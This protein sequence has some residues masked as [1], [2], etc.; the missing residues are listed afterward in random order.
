MNMTTKIMSGQ[1]VGRNPNG[2]LLCCG[3]CEGMDM[4]GSGCEMWDGDG[5]YVGQMDHGVREGEGKLESTNGNVYEGNW[6]NGLRVGRGVMRYAD[7]QT[8]EGTWK[9]GQWEDG[10][11]R[12]ADGSC[13]T[14]FRGNIIKQ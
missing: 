6:S 4:H 10:V 3:P 5:H 2:D 9:N 14:V 8:Y 11:M 7:G 1:G 13:R 12:S